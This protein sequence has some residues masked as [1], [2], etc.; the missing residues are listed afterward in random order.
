MGKPGHQRQQDTPGQQAP[1]QVLHG[2][3][4]GHRPARTPP[5][6]PYG[7]RAG[8]GKARGWPP[9]RSSSNATRPACRARAANHAACVAM[10]ARSRRQIVDFL[11][12]SWLI[13]LR[14]Y[15]FLREMGS[16]LLG[17]GRKGGFLWG[18]RV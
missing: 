15:W 6:L 2:L 17:G 18:G 12:Q 11:L 9:R 5:A 3:L 10:P 7:V 14:S 16:V 4:F 13:L 1:L 8:R